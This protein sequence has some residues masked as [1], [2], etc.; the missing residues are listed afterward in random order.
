[1]GRD[2]S[3]PSRSRVHIESSR[4]LHIGLVG[5]SC[6]SV[7]E[8]R[9]IPTLRSCGHS[10]NEMRLK[11]CPRVSSFSEAVSHGAI[12]IHQKIMIATASFSVFSS[13]PAPKILL[14]SAGHAGVQVPPSSDV[15]MKKKGHVLRK[16][17]TGVAA[18]FESGGPH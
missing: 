1:M 15:R 4:P 17:L 8:K 10:K 9:G 2:G 5:K 13:N 16:A 6:D 12:L 7:K 3:S 11:C 14:Y 18:G